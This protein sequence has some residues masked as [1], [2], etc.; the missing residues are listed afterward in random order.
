MR[1]IQQLRA[2]PVRVE[3]DLSPDPIKARIAGAED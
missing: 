1:P 3:S 2:E